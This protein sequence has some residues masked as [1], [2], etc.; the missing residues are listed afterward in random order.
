LRL[1]HLT[2]YP[3][4]GAPAWKG[5]QYLLILNIDYVLIHCENENLFNK[6]F[7]CPL[8]G[9]GGREQ[10]LQYKSNNNP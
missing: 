10:K 7:L 1:L 2:P 6:K 9:L 5:K 4:K 8:R 3:P